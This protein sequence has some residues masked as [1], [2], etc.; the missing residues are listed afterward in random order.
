MRWRFLLLLPLAPLVAT[1]SCNSVVIESPP[2]VGTGG[3]HGVQGFGGSGGSGGGVADA[4]DEYVDPGCPDA[5]MKMT[6]FMCDPYN[7]NNGN[8][9]PGQGCFIFATPPQTVCGQEIYGAECAPQG[10]GKQGDACDTGNSCSA[11]F[12]CVVTGSGNQ[13]VLLCELMG[14]ATCPPGFVCEP[15]DVQGFGGC[16]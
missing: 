15:I 12:S 4:G 3:H 6:D 16:L 14:A 10:P 2:V 5:G 1:A 13:C 11:G 8:C 9:P 7:Q